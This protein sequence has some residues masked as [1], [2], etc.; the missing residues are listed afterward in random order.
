M[1]TPGSRRVH[2]I[3]YLPASTEPCRVRMGSQSVVVL[4]LHGVNRLVSARA[5]SIISSLLNTTDTCTI[6]LD[7]RMIRVWREMN[8]ALGMRTAQRRVTYQHYVFTC[9]RESEQG[10]CILFPKSKDQNEFHRERYRS[11]IV[12]LKCPSSEDATV[13]KLLFNL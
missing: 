12:L 9:T 4:S 7:A 13:D 11:L 1:A 8:D 10:H 2:A 6:T 5:N 3:H